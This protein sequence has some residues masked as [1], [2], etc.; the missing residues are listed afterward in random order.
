MPN[1]K[2]A[3]RYYQITGQR[4][5]PELEAKSA[6]EIPLEP[7]GKVHLVRASINGIEGRF[8]LDTGASY[9]SVYQSA[10]KRFSLSPS[11]RQAEVHTANGTIQVP[12]TY[13]NLQVGQQK[14]N[15]AAVLLMPDSN[16]RAIDG[17]L[18]ND[19]LWRFDPE[20]DTRGNRLILRGFRGEK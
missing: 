11:T 7:S 1:S 17:L 18:G 14:L 19:F 8:V 3:E 16:D 6:S 4:V 13:G 15:G 12:V 2:A 5:P 10:A 20:I 9:T